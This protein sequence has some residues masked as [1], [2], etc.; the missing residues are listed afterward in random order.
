M[1]LAYSNVKWLL[2]KVLLQQLDLQL[3][4]SISLNGFE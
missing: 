1:F 2:V 4:I 3:K